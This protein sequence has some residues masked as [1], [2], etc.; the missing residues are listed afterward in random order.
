MTFR[1][2]SSPQGMDGDEYRTDELFVEFH[3]WTRWCQTVKE[4]E[5]TQSFC[6]FDAQTKTEWQ[7]QQHYVHDVPPMAST[8]T[9]S[10]ADSENI[11]GDFA[12]CQFVLEN[13]DNQ[14]LIDEIT[15]IQPGGCRR[16]HHLGLKVFDYSALFDLSE[17]KMTWMLN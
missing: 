4:R 11:L 14:L 3:A 2:T 8:E 17:R 1:T 10:R 16:S 12:V 5:Q 13:L 6:L 9:A 7:G 15:F